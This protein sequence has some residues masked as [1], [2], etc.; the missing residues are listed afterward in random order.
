MGNTCLYGAT[1]GT[2]FVRGRAG[3]RFAVRNSGSKAVVE[4]IGDHG[5]ESMTGG[6][7]VVLGST[8]RNFG[9][10]M[11]GGSAYVFDEANKLA[12]RHN[13]ELVD[14]IRVE[15]PDDVHTLRVMV[16]AHVEKTNSEVGHRILDNWDTEVKKFYKVQPREVASVEATQAAPADGVTADKS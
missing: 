16:T 3:E 15:N 9:A 1:G 6:L 8:G 14:L 12:I 5:C 7:V 4:G 11:T 13:P 10:G 2:L